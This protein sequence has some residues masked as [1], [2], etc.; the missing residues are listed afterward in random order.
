MKCKIILIICFLFLAFP[1]FA[2][3]KISEVGLYPLAGESQWIELLNDTSEPAP[4]DGVLIKGDQWEWRF[5]SMNVDVPQHTLVLV[6][7]DSPGDA[8]TLEVKDG[9]RVFHVPQKDVFGG[10]EKGY[11][12]LYEKENIV[13]RP[14]F[15]VKVFDYSKNGALK[16][17][18]DAMSQ[19][20][21]PEV[22]GQKDKF[23]DFVAWGD[24]PG[25]IGEDANSQGVWSGGSSFLWTD[26]APERMPVGPS[27]GDVFFDQR[28]KTLG[29]VNGGWKTLQ[30]GE[31]SPGRWNMEGLLPATIMPL[32]A[33]GGNDMPGSPFSFWWQNVYMFGGC[34]IEAQVATDEQFTNIVRTMGAESLGK[35]VPPLDLGTYWWRFRPLDG[36]PSWFDPQTASTQHAGWECRGRAEWQPPVRFEIR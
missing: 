2:G 28:G 19:A 34:N 20:A 1:A 5:S 4:I 36:L 25:K 3:W 26:P 16:G 23:V 9:V 13:S 6:R 15:E 18:Q 35:P 21:Q 33:N 12:A 17:L 14:A 22:T 10:P 32:I 29:I 24:E 11:C 7:F 8:A 27:M 30:P 31:A